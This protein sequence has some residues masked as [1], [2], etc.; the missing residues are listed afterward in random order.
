MSRVGRCGIT[1]KLKSRQ[2]S[3]YGPLLSRFSRSLSH[4]GPRL[5]IARRRFQNGNSTPSFLRVPLVLRQSRYQLPRQHRPLPCASTARATTRTGLETACF[6]TGVNE[7]H[8]YG[9]AKNG[10]TWVRVPLWR[11]LGIL[12]ASSCAAVIGG[13]FAPL[14]TFMAIYTTP[15]TRRNAR[16]LALWHVVVALCLIAQ[17]S[18][19]VNVPTRPLGPGLERS[20]VRAPTDRPH[21]CPC[22]TKTQCGQ[23]ELDPCAA[24]PR[25]LAFHNISRRARDYWDYVH[26]HHPECVIT[27]PCTDFRASHC[28]LPP[29]ILEGGGD[30]G[31]W[32]EAA[33]QCYQHPDQLAFCIESALRFL[34]PYS[35]SYLRWPPLCVRT[36][37]HRV[38]QQCQGI[39]EPA[40]VKLVSSYAYEHDIFTLPDPVAVGKITLHTEATYTC[41]NEGDPFSCSDSQN[42]SC[43]SIIPSTTSDTAYDIRP[44]E[45]LRQSHYHHALRVACSWTNNFLYDLIEWV[46]LDPKHNLQT[47]VVW[48]RASISRAS[49]EP[50][51]LEIHDVSCPGTGLVASYQI[52]TG[53]TGDTY[54]AGDAAVADVR[55]F[56]VTAYHTDRGLRIGRTHA[57]MSGLNLQ[58]YSVQFDIRNLLPLR[59]LQPYHLFAQCYE[60]AIDPRPLE[61]CSFLKLIYRGLRHRDRGLYQVQQAPVPCT[62]EPPSS[63]RLTILHLGSQLLL[64]PGA[65]LHINGTV[66]TVPPAPA[67]PSPIQLEMDKL[68]IQY[69]FFTFIAALS[70]SVTELLTDPISAL[71]KFTIP[72]VLVLCAYFSARKLEWRSALAAIA[73]LYFLYLAP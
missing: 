37:V 44:P 61:Q 63:K 28:P 52:L 64:V 32:A 51:T 11:V 24:M 60:Y 8:N 69:N 22:L 48:W 2:R 17:A 55:Q 34:A 21:N 31:C 9:S 38:T 54:A 46:G 62:L 71:Q 58:I 16:I 19:T 68:Q 27:T 23:L 72:T 50:Y 49:T 20:P 3:R 4:H 12:A 26:D 73:T 65:L 39:F 36:D 40:N 33:F 47:P 57:V 70:A 35:P 25:H 59:H 29:L 10:V 41:T 15:Q 13:L 42:Y 30:A 53:P 7:E 67:L 45:A 18:S 66:I 43:G 5:N 14:S 6:T 56:G 1:G